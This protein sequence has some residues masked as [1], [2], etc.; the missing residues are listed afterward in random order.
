MKHRF[1]RLAVLALGASLGSF[2]GCSDN[3][4]PASAS[5]DQGLECEVV[6][7]LCHEAASA[8]GQDCH[9]SAHHGRCG[10]ASC[11]KT[12]IP[13]ADVAGADV[14]CVA[15]GELCHPVADLARELRE[16]HELGHGNDPERCVAS[17]EDCATRC[18]AAREELETP[19][20]GGA[21]GSGPDDE[22][23]HPVAGAGGAAP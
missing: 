10:F 8:A 9:E 6:G 1:R 2:I 5:S 14:R 20:P 15:L 19:S 21:G 17:F 22:H 18:L 3:D 12:C 23:D 11:V 16:C 4:Q 7:E 13:K